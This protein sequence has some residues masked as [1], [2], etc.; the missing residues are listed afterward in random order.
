MKMV[1]VIF[2]SLYNIF[3]R[4]RSEIQLTQNRLK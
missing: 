1:E 3:S 4:L 2:G